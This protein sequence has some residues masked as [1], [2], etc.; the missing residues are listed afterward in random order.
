[1]TRE[2]L[3][4]GN[5]TLRQPQPLVLLFHSF[6][7]TGQGL[8]ADT[9]YARRAVE[10]GFMAAYPQAVGDPP[11]WDFASERDVRFVSLLLDKLEESLCIDTNRV[12]VTGM[13]QGGGM[14]NLVGCRLSDRIAA[15][16]AVAGTYGPSYGG[17]CDSERP[18]PVLALHALDDDV[19]PYAGGAIADG[20]I[21]QLPPVMPVENWA[22][23]WAAR[24]GCGRSA[25]ERL[26]SGGTEL[27]WPG[28]DADVR[29]Y[30]L[31]TGDHDWP[32]GP[33]D[34]AKAIS[35]SDVIWDFFSHQ[36]LAEAH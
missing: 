1:M 6:A 14:A 26:V 29:L 25:I 36:A 13:S 2:A 15:I 32:G 21:A 12:V 20:R 16:A 35:A 27:S 10:Q 19:V 30:R 24:D 9:D 8:D 34:S 5:A 33:A 17:P 23:D 4:R 31:D 28:C 18:V 7:G 11:S 22:A 3:V